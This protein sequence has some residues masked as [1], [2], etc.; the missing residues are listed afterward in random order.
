MPLEAWNSI[1]DG[2]GLHEPEKKPYSAE[3]TATPPVLRAA[4]MQKIST[5]T[6]REDPRNMLATPSLCVNRLGRSRPKK[7]AP[8]RIDTCEEDTGR[9]RRRFDNL[10]NLVG[11]PCKKKTLSSVRV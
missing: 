8:F 3:N 1:D 6:A 10:E 2:E 9:I 5:V 4:S 7:D 11:L